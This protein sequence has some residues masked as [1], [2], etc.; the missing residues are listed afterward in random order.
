M[1]LPGP[2]SVQTASKKLNNL[3]RHAQHYARD[4]TSR[5]DIQISYLEMLEGQ[6]NDNLRLVQMLAR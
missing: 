4:R 1:D 3:K 2:P 5:D 6:D